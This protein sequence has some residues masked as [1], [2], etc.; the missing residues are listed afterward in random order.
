MDFKFPVGTYKVVCK[1]L[2]TGYQ[3]TRKITV[4][5]DKYGVSYNQYGVSEDGKTLLVV[6]LPSGIGETEK[7]G[8]TWYMTEFERTCP[9]CGSHELYWGIFWGGDEV[10][11]KAVF[12]ATGISEHGA[13]EGNIFCAECDSDFSIFGQ[14]HE[15]ADHARGWDLKVVSGPVKSSKEIAYILKSGN[16]VKI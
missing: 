12:P 14:N 10:T 16:Y 2:A 3:V 11:E 9:Y 1:D 13:L 15:P 4:V 5:K 7:Y 6:G 8:F